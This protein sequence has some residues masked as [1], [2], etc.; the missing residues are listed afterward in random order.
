MCVGREF[1][2]IMCSQKTWI[3]KGLMYYI[4]SLREKME[5]QYILLKLELIKQIKIEI[6]LS[7]RFLKG[8]VCSF[9]N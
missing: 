4:L 7:V 3:I 6:V 5:I 8:V 2:T 1:T 9:F